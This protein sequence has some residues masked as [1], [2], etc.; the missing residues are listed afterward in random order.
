MARKSQIRWWF[1]GVEHKW[2][3]LAVL[4]AGFID[5]KRLQIAS[6]QHN[7]GIWVIQS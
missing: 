1:S 6:H 2:Q 4:F 5:E 7:F 3:L